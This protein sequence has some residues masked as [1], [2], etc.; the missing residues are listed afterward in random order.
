M[1]HVKLI[2]LKVR[3]K[4][5]KIRWTIVLT[6]YTV[7]FIALSS[8][9]NINHLQHD[10]AL[11]LRALCLYFDVGHKCKVLYSVQMQTQHILLIRRASQRGE[12]YLIHASRVRG[13]IAWPLNLTHRLAEK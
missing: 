8:K 12:A 6:V 13:E 5:R 10:T 9:M 3:Q 2:Q 7:H 1:Y 4:Q 11:A